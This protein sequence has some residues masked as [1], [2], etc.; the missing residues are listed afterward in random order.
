MCPPTLAAW[1]LGYGLHDTASLPERS[2]KRKEK[3]KFVKSIKT[4]LVDVFED[5]FFRDYVVCGAPT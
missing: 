2:E 3:V 5:A 1:R 4:P